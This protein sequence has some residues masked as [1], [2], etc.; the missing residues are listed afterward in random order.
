M[1]ARVRRIMQP[2][3]I[4]MLS[5]TVSFLAGGL[6][7]NT[8]VQQASEQQTR[9]EETQRATQENLTFLREAFCGLVEPI[10]ITTPV[11]PAGVTYRDSAAKT[12]RALQCTPD[13][14]DGK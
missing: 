2:L 6:A 10:S 13:P 3:P 1:N 4:A 8:S 12:A 5:F 7:L 14:T 9:A 11:T